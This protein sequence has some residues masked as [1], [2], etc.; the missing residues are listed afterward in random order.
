MKKSSPLVNGTQKNIVEQQ[1]KHWQTLTSPFINLS[2]YSFFLESSLLVCN[3]LLQSSSASVIK[4]LGWRRIFFVLKSPFAVEKFRIL[5]WN[6]ADIIEIGDVTIGGFGTAHNDGRELFNILDG[7]T[8]EWI[9]TT[10]IWLYL[11]WIIK[12]VHLGVVAWTQ[13]IVWLGDCSLLQLLA[14]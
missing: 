4:S 8:L 5:L 11:R 3:I 12:R 10:C 2:E 1:L 13:I 7:R 9:M 6:V 14:K